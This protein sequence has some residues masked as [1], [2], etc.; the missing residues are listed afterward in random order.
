MFWKNS[1]VLSWTSMFMLATFREILLPSSGKEWWLVS[2]SYALMSDLRENTASVCL[3]VCFL[4]LIGWC[5]YF[6]SSFKFQCRKPG[7][8]K[9]VWYSIYMIVI[10]EWMDS[11]FNFSCCCVG[12]IIHYFLVFPVKVM[13]V[14]LTM[15]SS[16]VS[17]GISSSYSSGVFFSSLCNCSFRLSKIDSLTVF[18]VIFIDNVVPLF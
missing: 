17:S 3:V 9:S 12:F 5:V 13:V 11:F 2:R 8:W 15:I 10:T 4:I 16:F 6:R 7:V 14:F 1:F 18:A